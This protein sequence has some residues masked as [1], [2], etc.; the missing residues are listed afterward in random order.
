MIT[1]NGRKENGR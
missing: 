1:K